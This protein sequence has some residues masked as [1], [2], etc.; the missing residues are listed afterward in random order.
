MGY[1]V[2]H[3]LLVGGEAH[4]CISE[5]M[6]FGITGILYPSNLGLPCGNRDWLFGS[7]GSSI[8]GRGVANRRSGPRPV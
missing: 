6:E 7:V 5:K 3:C 8:K 4:R 1:H 2:D